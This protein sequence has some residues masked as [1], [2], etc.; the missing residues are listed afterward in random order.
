MI[1]LYITSFNAPDQFSRMVQ[2]LSDYDFNFI[3]NTRKFLID[4]STDNSYEKYHEICN[5]WGFEH[6]KFDNLGIMGSRLFA[7]KHFD[8]SSSSHYLYFEDDMILSKY[9]KC[10][11]GYLRWHTQILKTLLGIMDKEDFDF[12]KLN[13]TEVELSNKYDWVLSIEKNPMSFAGN[14]KLIEANFKKKD[15]YLN[16]EYLEGGFCLNNW[17]MLMS[18]RGNWLCYIENKFTKMSEYEI[19]R[20]IHPSILKGKIKSSVLLLSPVEHNRFQNYKGR[21][22]Y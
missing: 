4:N 2:S 3:C 15:S 5:T 11:S 7:A 18:K 21:K 6:L 8:L 19:S 14:K 1:S 16:L 12:I 20:S 10:K 13:F 17:P 9:G 22:E